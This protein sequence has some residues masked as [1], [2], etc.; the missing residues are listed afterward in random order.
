M[1]KDDGSYV[2]L[3]PNGKVINQNSSMYKLL[4]KFYGANNQTKKK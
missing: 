3:D 2:M 1:L 4:P